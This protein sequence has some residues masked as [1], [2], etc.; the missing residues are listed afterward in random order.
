[1]QIIFGLLLLS[2]YHPFF[3]VYGLLL[4]GLAFVLFKYTAEKGL[5]TSL[6]ESKSK[7]KVAHWLQEI[8]RSLISFKLS[9]V[10]THAVDKNDE[11]VS[12]YLNYR[13]QH[14]KVSHSSG[15]QFI[16]FKVLITA[17]LLLIGGLLVLNQEMNIGQFVA[18]ELIILIIIGA[19]E[20]DHF[21]IRIFL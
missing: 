19:V 2:F 12:D 17:G 7:Y 5:K 8:A 21:W 6:K 20:K 18:A 9:G 16:G 15:F 3:I 13:E 4:V 14:F 11:L 10:T 1:M